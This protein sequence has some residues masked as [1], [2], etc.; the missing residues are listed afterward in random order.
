LHTAQLNISFVPDVWGQNIRAVES[1][2]ALTEQA[3]FQL[4]AAYL[5][6]TA[7]VISAAIQEASLRGQIAATERILRIDRDILGII[8]R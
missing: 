1:L 6:L 2:D 7:N 8:K 4:E 3:K 5:A